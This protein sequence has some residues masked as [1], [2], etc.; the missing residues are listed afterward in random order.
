MSAIFT[1]PTQELPMRGAASANHSGKMST[2][3]RRAAQLLFA[4]S[5]ASLLAVPSSAADSYAVEGYW[6]TN[7][8]NSIVEIAPCA[9]SRKRLCGTLVWAADG[10][11]ET[12][13]TQ[14]LKSF[15]L[16]GNKAGDK[17]GQGKILVAGSKKGK[18]GKLALNDD[19]LKV[20]TCKGSTCKNKTW[21]R[22][23]ATM[24]AQA[25]LPSG[26]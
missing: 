7:G 3:G 21:T 15:R 16:A 8:G 10:E 19:T 24:T 26:A 22:P 6:L 11:A 5:C 4:A 17:W 1:S 2:F 23:S 18:A 25:G 12:V 13:G 14:V 20:S 9:Q